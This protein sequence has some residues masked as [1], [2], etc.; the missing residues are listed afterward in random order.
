MCA[1]GCSAS[2]R[3]S[4][5]YASTGNAGGRGP[6]DVPAFPLFILLSS[7]NTLFK[8]A[9]SS[10]VSAVPGVPSEPGRFRIFFPMTPTVLASP[11]ISACSSSAAMVGGAGC[12]GVR[13]LTVGDIT[14]GDATCAGCEA[15]RAMFNPT[16]CTE[17]E[18]VAS[19]V[20]PVPPPNGSKPAPFC[21]I[22]LFCMPSI[23]GR[24]I[25]P[26]GVE[27]T[28]RGRSTMCSGMP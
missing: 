13:V 18:S 21:C 8:T 28:I 23:I 16:D 2:T 4:R 5:A 1:A 3:S 20:R 10:S 22:M 25:A 6:G 24:S 11:E 19:S 17:S 15:L 27:N 14:E 9:F 7:D 26:P 12:S